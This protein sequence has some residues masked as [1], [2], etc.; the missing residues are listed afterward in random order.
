MLTQNRPLPSILF[1]FI[2]FIFILFFIYFFIFFYRPQ[3]ITKVAIMNTKSGS[4]AFFLF[5]SFLPPRVERSFLF[6]FSFSFAWV[7]FELIG[8][9]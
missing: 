5:S 4:I 6:F 1:Y 7:I 2:L 3:A 8:R 9:T